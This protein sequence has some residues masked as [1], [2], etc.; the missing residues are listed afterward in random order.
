MK[1]SYTLHY[2]K[3]YVAEAISILLGIISL[4][5]VVPYI[6]D[7]KDIYG[8]Y[9]L[10]V[11]TL[12]FLSYADL[13]FLGAAMKFSAEYFQLGEKKKEIEVL[14]FGGFVLFIIAAFISLG[15]LVLSFRP[16]LLISGI[17]QSPHYNT[18]RHLFL[19]M[20]LL[21][22]FIGLQRLTQCIF[23]IRVENYIYQFINIVGS[24]LRILSVF[25][26]FSN[27]KYQIV[28]YFAFI[29]IVPILC[30]IVALL[31]A[32][33][34]Y[35]YHLPILIKSFRWNKECFK[36]T[37]DLAISSF[38]MTI[39]WILYYEMDQIVI[40]KLYG[41]EKVALYAIAFSI[42]NYIRMFLG[43]FFSPFTPRF[44]HF[45]ADGD[46]DGLKNFYSTTVQ[47]TFPIVAIP[48]L[49]ATI[50]S[51]QFVIAWS[52]Q[53]YKDAVPLSILFI[54]LNFTASFNYLGASII[55]VF[56]KTKALKFLS[57]V[58]PIVYWIGIGVLPKCLGIMSFGIMKHVVFFMTITIYTYG[59]VHLLGINIKEMLIKLIRNDL[60]PL[61]I[62]SILSILVYQKISFIEKSFT[63]LLMICGIILSISLVGYI[64]TLYS[65]REVH[66][67]VFSLIGKFKNR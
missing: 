36:I 56:E 67:Y 49:S 17:I 59:T 24:V 66:N 43:G 55:T 50:L 6:S 2:L 26:F 32:C 35:D 22:P 7:N 51:E 5:V 21:S 61:I 63:S 11:S 29:Q 52:G 27:G 54:L 40:A 44:A 39:S 18:A 34:R 16:D 30:S 46:T 37:K 15:Y 31:I 45:K 28:E 65:N 64:I 12:V 8:V 41:P 10:C 23:S 58:L 33:Q 1:D 48:I 57:I 38:F 3:I 4:F 25:F 42:L 14:S 9:S 47:I 62:V 53:A 19:I 60:V 13:G 20:A